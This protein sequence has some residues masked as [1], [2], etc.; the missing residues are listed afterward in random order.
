MDA[1]KIGDILFQWDDRNYRLHPGEFMEKFRHEGPWDGETV[2]FGGSFAHLKPF[3]EYPKLGSGELYDI[4]MVD[5]EPLLVYPWAYLR[6]AYGIWPERI[7]QGRQDVCIFDPGIIGQERMDADWFFGICGLQKA[8]L[9][10]GHPV[11]HASY[12]DCNGSGIL[13]TA[14]SQ[15]GKSTQAALWR[16]CAGAQVINGDRV[17]LGKRAGQWHAHG[18]PNCGSS[19]VC[20]N[21]SVPIKAIVVLEQA[22][23]NQIV[24]M[25]TAQQIRAVAGAT[26]VYSWCAEDLDRAFALAEEIIAEVPVVKLRCLPDVGAVSV[27]QQYL[28]ETHHGS[29]Q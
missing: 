17:L 4:Y 3:L 2:T 20:V 6:H 18:F 22:V 27:L 28:E 21:R 26:S 5:G 12:I 14:P 11:L 16:D 8:L 15:T 1:Y 25:S 9:M 10:R 29:G 19:G 24:P 7:T 13:F 23:E